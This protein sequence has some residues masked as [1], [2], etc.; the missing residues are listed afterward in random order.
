M[1]ILDVYWA[2]TTIVLI[3]PKF[4][5]F[6]FFSIP[7]SR[8]LHNYLYHISL[9]TPRV[10]TFHLSLCFYDWWRNLLLATIAI[11]NK[12]GKI[13]QKIIWTNI[14]F[15]PW[16]LIRSQKWSLTFNFHFCDPQHI[17]RLSKWSLTFK[18]Y[19]YGY[20]YIFLAQ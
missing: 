7:R 8:F 3:A 12:H 10:S 11:L 13:N 1:F 15:S 9:C 14:M 18:F 2:P 4:S 19:F 5:F 20:Q 16:H 6:F 17:F